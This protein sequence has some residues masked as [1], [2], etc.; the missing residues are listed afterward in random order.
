MAGSALATPNAKAQS[1]L[2]RP[3]TPESAAS[4]ALLNNRGIRAQV[5]E[6]GI[7]EAELASARRLP[8]PT[9]EA[10]VRFRGDDSPDI[11]V[12]GLLDVTDLLF[13]A[14]RSSVAAGKVDAAKLDAVG[15]VLDLSYHVRRAF[16]RFQASAE[17]LELR[18][19]VLHA[20]E[21]SADLA[22]RLREAGNIT[23][24]DLAIQE[25]SFE[26]ARLQFQQAEVAL[27]A[28]R[29]QLNALLG[30]WGTGTEW[31]AEPRLPPP[32]EHELDVAKLE[33]ESIARSLDLAIAKQRYGVAARR[34]NLASVTGIFPELK[35]GVSAERDEEW[36]IGP[37]VEI[38]VPL[39]YQG[40]GE[41]AA[42]KAEMRR[43][44]ERFADK[45][46]AIRAV[47]RSTAATLRTK[48]DVV[49]YYKSSLLPL[50]QKVVEQSQLEYNA[51]LI[52]V[53]QLLAAK[54]DQVQTAATYVEQLRDYWIARTDAEQ[55][56]AGRLPPANVASVPVDTGTRSLPAAADAH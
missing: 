19:T 30:V 50:K 38:E 37:A 48:R 39:F 51:M 56:L 52:G 4:V 44:R 34:A 1:L 25:S 40:Q 43:E 27:I 29:E 22:R 54:R 18:R 2:A 23:E 16:F 7:A 15:T 24:L 47:A 36:A 13:L 31:N 55:L 26:E 5:E 17:I 10:A 32:P 11:E 33:T 46:V 41:V 45:A 21:A 53:F 9:A 49:G 20:F 8:N 6:L 35:A 42:A 3:L 28:A 14:S 12:S